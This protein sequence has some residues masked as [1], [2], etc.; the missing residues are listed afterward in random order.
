M[1]EKK[2]K[3]TD[4][5]GKVGDAV[6]GTKAKSMEKNAIKKQRQPQPKKTRR[7]IPK[8]LQSFFENRN[9]SWPEYAMLKVQLVILAFFLTAVVYLVFFP[10]E[11]LI[12]IFLLTVFSA[13]LIYLTKTQI[14]RAFGR[15][16][17][18]Y[19][20]FV[21]M[22]I[23]VAWVFVTIIKFFT[24]TYAIET[25]QLVLIPPMIAIGFVAAAF[26]FFRLKYGRNFTYGTVEETRGRRAMVRIGY[27][28]RSNVKA[29]LYTVES[30][31][32]VKRGDIVKI[33][34]E[35]PMLGMRGAKVKAIL[36]K[37]K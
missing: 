37:S 3:S 27:D 30:F 8:R 34:V 31:A 15:D 20:G 19:R 33:G 13:C 26:L 29:G 35:R 10:G 36:E 17:P 14:K 7:E 23:A 16:Y 11:N 12:F 21:V 18:A 22:C 28:I 4:F 6:L 25:M 9:A 2:S 5:F 24:V 32:K 1:S